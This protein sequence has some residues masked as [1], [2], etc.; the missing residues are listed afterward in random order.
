MV[1]ELLVRFLMKQKLG[2]NQKMNLLMQTLI[3]ALAASLLFCVTYRVWAYDFRIPFPY[4]NGDGMFFSSVVKTVMESGWYD[5][6][7]N[8][9]APFGRELFDFPVFPDLSSI[10]TI[11]ILAIFFRDYALLINFWTFAIFPFTAVITFLVLKKLKVSFLCA[12]GGALCYS[13]LSFRYLR[14]LIGH[15]FLADYSLIPVMFLIFFWLVEDSRFFAIRRDFFRYKRNIF[16]IVFLLFFSLKGVYYTFFSCFFVA[17]ILLMLLVRTRKFR[18]IIPA[19]LVMLCLSIPL[20]LAYLPTFIYRMENGI[21]PLAPN[22]FPSE[23]EVLSLEIAFLFL[24]E[25]S[26]RIPF[27]AEKKESFVPL[28]YSEGTAY[29]GLAGVVGFAVLLISL[30]TR[31]RSDKREKM[32][33]SGDRIYFLGQLQIFGVLLGTVGGFG[34]LFAVFINSQIRAYNRISVFLALFSIAGFC[35]AVDLLLQS[36]RKKWVKGVLGAF[37]VLFFAVAILEQS[38]FSPESRYVEIKSEFSSDANFIK[39]I[40]NE[41]DEGSM[42]LQFPYQAFPEVPPVERMEDYSHTRAYLHSDS[43]RWSYG[44]YKGREGDDFIRALMEKP[45][46]EMLPEAAKEGFRGIYVDTYGYTEE[47][48]AELELKLEICL[49]SNRIVSDNGR[50]WFYEILI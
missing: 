41:V 44:A 39:M 28:T 1:N 43:L 33:I 19:L 15:F 8:L 23:S 47:D 34:P 9:G 20:V 29:M 35:L 25:Q 36:R 2:D 5:F 21:N 22:R 49:A 4:T 10:L 11:R 37:T 46:E 48:L 14:I 45:L 17:I 42:I 38:S 3:V 12:A 27:L 16:A 26:A 7:E 31:G 50:L 40:E 6:N 13:F 24:P 18:K 32:T 30:F